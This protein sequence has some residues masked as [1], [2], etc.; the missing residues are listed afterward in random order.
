MSWRFGDYGAA[1]TLIGGL[2]LAMALS[3]RVLRRRSHRIA[4]T[5]GLLVVLALVWAELAVGLFD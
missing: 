4:V 5:L 2:V 3:F 1:A